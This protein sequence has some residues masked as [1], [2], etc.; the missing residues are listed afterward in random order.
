VTIRHLLQHQSGI[1]DFTEKLLQAYLSAGH[2]SQRAAMDHLLK[3]LTGGETALATSPGQTWRYSNFGYELLALAAERIEGRPFAEVVR[4]RV[5]APAGMAS[6]VI[7]M[8]DPRRDVLQGLS[9]PGL[10]A[11]FNG[12]PDARSH[13]VA[14]YSFIQQGAGAVVAS[15]QDLLA[16][17]KALRSRR[18]LSDANRARMEAD[19]VTASATAR[20]GYGLMVRTSGKCAYWQHSGG[21]NGYVSEFAVVPRAQA[22]VVILSNFGFSEP[23]DYRKEIVDILA[24]QVGCHASPAG[25]AG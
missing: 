6:A 21:N 9:V 22:T 15:R 25:S 1:P 23:S 8:A 20:Y 19:A 18:L 4:L 2:R 11:G 16:L 3:S 13:L 24:R 12:S 7:E 10:V 14:S 17:G 5:F